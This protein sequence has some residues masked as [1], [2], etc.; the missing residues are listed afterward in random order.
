MARA[1]YLVQ[2]STSWQTGCSARRRCLLLSRNLPEISHPSKEGLTLLLF[3]HGSGSRGRD[4][5]PKQLGGPAKLIDEARKFPAVVVSTQC[6]VGQG[7]EAYRLRQLLK[8]LQARL[9]PERVVVTGYSM[10]ASG[11]WEF[12][13]TCPELIGAAAPVCGC[14]DPWQA[15]KLKGVPVWRFLN[16]T[17]WFR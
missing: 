16:W 7:W 6:T 11:T 4:I 12:A 1:G 15:E 5:D 3:L 13:Q 10:G 8:S 2:S 17:R 14:R 9:N